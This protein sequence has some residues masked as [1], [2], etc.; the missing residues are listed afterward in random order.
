MIFYEASLDIILNNKQ[1][2]KVLIRLH[3]YEDRPALLLFACIKVRFS[4]AEDHFNMYHYASFPLI[5]CLAPFE[6]NK[7]KK[8]CKDQ[9]KCGLMLMTSTTETYFNC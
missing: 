7:S 3:A 5:L 4:H 6:S 8:G 2:V 1:T 9:L